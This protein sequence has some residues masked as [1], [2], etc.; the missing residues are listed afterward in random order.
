[1][2]KTWILAVTAAA[3]LALAGCGSSS[4]A[5]SAA[6]GAGDGT[7]SSS[8]PAAMTDL[9]SWD[10][11]LGTVV[12]DSSGQT[13]YMFD[14]DTAGADSACTGTCVPLWPALTTTS[15]TPTVTG[16]T[17]AVG[18]APTADGKQQVTLDGHRLYVFSGDSGAQQINGQGFMNLWW[19]VAPDGT[20]VTGT[21]ASSSSSAPTS[22]SDQP[23]Y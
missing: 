4:P 21:A 12:V 20:K 2:R 5:G 11:P 1:V 16:V 17:G 23:S 18:T 22:A 8:S 19:A 7:T 6:S 14:K 13:V 15:S 9:A 3:S 10:S